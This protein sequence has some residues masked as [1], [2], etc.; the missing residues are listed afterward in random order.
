VTA[1]VGARARVALIALG[2]LLVLDIGRSVYARVGHASPTELWQPAPALYADLAWPPGSDVPASASPGRRL[3]ARW[4]A[5]CHGPDGRGN[6]P[7]AP[8]LIPRPR[9]LT[10]GLFKYK[11]TP[12][13]EPPTDD[14]LAHIVADGLQASAMPHFR[15][16][17]TAG[18]IRDVIA[19]VKTLSPVFADSARRP[20]PI[21]ARVPPDAASL[22]RGREL[23][24]E[25]GC[26]RCHGP[27]GRRREVQRDARGYPV[28][29]RDLTAPWTFAGGSNPE[30]VWL[31]LT[32]MSSET[33]MPSYAEAVT[34]ADRWHVVNYVL[35]LARTPPWQA[36]GRLDGPGQ[37]P[38]PVIR[39]Q[40][41][42]HA[43]MCGLCHTQ[44]NPTGIYRGD[45]FYLA[46]GMRVGA[47]PQGVFVSR[48]LTA[49]PETG[50]GRWSEAEIATAIRD[51]R[52]RGRLLNIWGM[53]WMF[54]HRLTDADA[55]AIAAYL[56]TLPPVRNAI[57][58]PLHYGM[59]ETLAVK[60]TRT[61]PAMP[62][63]VLTYAEGNFG[64]RAGGLARDIPQRVLV[65]AQ[66]LI[67]VAGVVGFVVAGPRG[68]RVP[69]TVRGWLLTAVVT[70]GLLV[71]AVL[72]VV[73]ARLP[74]LAVIPPEQI[75]AATAGRIPRPDPAR[76]G[77]N[78]QARLVERGRYLFAVA[79]CA[80]CHGTDGA[81]GAKLSWRPM[82]T[83]WA[84][85]LTPDRETGLGAWT[86]AE[87]ARAIRSGIAKGGRPLH[88]Q[89]MIW[90]HASNWD[91]EDVRA[92][93]AFLRVLP[94]VRRAVPTARPPAADDCQVYTF[95]VDASTTPGCR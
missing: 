46:G 6:G 57:P 59:L 95:W 70:I 45:D 26:D 60:L 74:T 15:D 89:A 83:A 80:L 56:K 25:L 2:A 92:L 7:A 43:E 4:C 10:R 69:H 61:P 33:P 79:S 12:A 16:V 42:V 58:E 53:P 62:P 48:N 22:A 36:E 18:E 13:A 86:D 9:D 68:S 81:G 63:K 17:L 3:Y 29:T 66:W 54:L 5:T 37:H 71:L 49:D 39:G 21:P 34:P 41:L 27:D 75:A 28:L 76:L 87:I 40:Y 90:D 91:E 84:R 52:A 19:H 24:A 14:D 78:P 32:T 85:N 94:P 73:I 67:L 72:A 11:S 44:I 1:L 47:Y 51:G 8:S 88:W 64:A 38:D 50:L 35:S 77:G 23:Y 31:R 55:R 93:V 82:G 65:T 30:Q 20:V